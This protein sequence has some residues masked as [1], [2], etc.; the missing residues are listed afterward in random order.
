MESRK[1][2]RESILWNRQAPSKA[3]SKEGWPMETGELTIWNK[4]TISQAS[5]KIQ[6]Q[7]MEPLL[8]RPIQTFPISSSPISPKGKPLSTIKTTADM[9]V[10]DDNMVG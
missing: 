9:K 6:N 3:N 5:G 10:F 7:R 1:A 8:S 2:L 4:S